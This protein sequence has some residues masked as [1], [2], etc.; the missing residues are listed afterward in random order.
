MW[1]NSEAAYCWIC[2]Q[3]IL[4]R[5]RVL[6]W[7]HLEVK[8]EARN[9]WIALGFFFSFPFVY[10]QWNDICYVGMFSPAVI[11]WLWRVLSLQ[12]QYVIVPGSCFFCEIFSPA[13]KTCCCLPN[14]PYPPFTYDWLPKDCFETSDFLQGLGKALSFSIQVCLAYISVEWCMGDILINL[15][16][17]IGNFL[18][19]YILEERK[20]WENKAFFG[21]LGILL[22]TFQYTSVW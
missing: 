21:E 4:V 6:F 8:T 22:L 1:C 15:Q 20:L 17:L 3:E 9:I 5:G 7:Q 10:V 16:L 13:L 18:R 11:S 14:S 19:R 12:R 2:L